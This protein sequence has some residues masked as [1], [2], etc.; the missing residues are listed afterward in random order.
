MADINLSGIFPPIPT[1]FINGKVAHEELAE[2]VKKWSKTGI[3]GLVVFGS[4]GEYVYLSEKEKRD[5]IE[6]VVQNAPADFLIIAGSGCESTEA[7]LKLTCDCGSLGADAALVATPHYYSNQMTENALMKH[8]TF[9][10]EHSPIPIILYNVP[11]FTHITLAPDLVSSLSEHPNI[12]GIKD[13]SGNIHL[14]SEFLNQVGK[15]FDVLVGTAG[16]WFAGLTLGCTGGILALA[17]ITPENCVKVFE[18][19]K[20]NEYEKARTLQLKMIPVNKIITTI[21]GI[22]GLKA[23]M[24]MLGYF[25]GDPRPPLLPPSEK[26]K[27][28]IKEILQKAD[29]L[30]G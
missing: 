3:N 15:H 25:G 14:L 9:I 22:G 23:A 10:A 26:E 28:E 30:P 19:F 11:K 20:K 18:L 12:I 27:F 4:N 6:T 7:T 13:S 5:V 1:P 8:F 24:D 16:V 2:N 21:Y 29:I 17:N